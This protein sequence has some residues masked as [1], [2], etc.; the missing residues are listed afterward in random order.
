[1][2]TRTYLALGDS[3]TIGEAVPLYQSFPYQ[4]IQLLR[5]SGHVF[6]APEIVATTG[7]TTGELQKGISYTSFLKSY[8]IVSLLIGV[9]NQYRGQQIEQYAVE[10]EAL[11]QCAISFA[12][13]H[14]QVVVLSIP[15]WSVT[16]FAAASLPDEQGRDVQQVSA[17]IDAYNNINASITKTYG[18]H[19]IDITPGTRL[20]AT[21]ESLLAKDKLHP[22]GKAY[23]QWAMAFARVAEQVIG[24]K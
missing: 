22:S 16:P 15:D 7:W 1:M 21:D 11:L 20:A 18:A 3:Y 17:E 2:M 6:N 5:K 13:N 9:N 8:D 14:Q 12:G 24:D 4:A 23:K 10:F 19:Y